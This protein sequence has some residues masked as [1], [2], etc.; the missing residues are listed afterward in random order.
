MKYEVLIKY[1]NGGVSRLRVRDRTTWCL[2]QARKHL[3]D[4]TQ[5]LVNGERTEWL[6]VC[7]A[8]A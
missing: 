6:Y 5:M 2:R 3:R 8:E 7:L 4:C 1:R